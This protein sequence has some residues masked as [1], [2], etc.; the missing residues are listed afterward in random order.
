LKIR[1]KPSFS[2]SKGLTEAARGDL[3]CS[4]ALPAAPRQHPGAELVLLL[5]RVQGLQKEGEMVTLSRGKIVMW[6]VA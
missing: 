1:R 4:F 3:L 2:K 5:L 6:L